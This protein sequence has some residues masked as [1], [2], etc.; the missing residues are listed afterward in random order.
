MKKGWQR[1][2]I[3]KMTVLEINMKEERIAKGVNKF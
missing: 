3:K 2:N 1:P